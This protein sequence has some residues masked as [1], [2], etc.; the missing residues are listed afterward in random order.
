MTSEDQA[1]QRSIQINEKPPVETKP[2]ES[3]KQF[4]SIRLFLSQYGFCSLDAMYHMFNSKQWNDSKYF[5]RLRPSIKLLDSNT[6]SFVEDL[7]NL[8]RISPMLY[9]TGQIYYLKRHQQNLNESFENL[10]CPEE[11]NPNFLTMVSKLGKVIEVNRHGGWTG[12]LETSWKTINVNASTSNSTTKTL[13][14]IDGLNSIFYW[15]DLTSEMAFYLPHQFS[16]EQQGS[17]MRIV[18][19]WLEEFHNDL[20]SLLPVQD[21]SPKS[22]EI[23]IIGIHPLKNG[24]FR[25]ALNPTAQRMQSTCASIP[26]LDGM[27]VPSY[28]LSFFLRQ[29]V[30]SLNRRK[31]LEDSQSSQTAYSL[32]KSRITKIIEKYQ[33]RSHQLD[34]YFEQI[35]FSTRTASTV[36]QC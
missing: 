10:N 31:R 26:F 1:L 8:D 21:Q 32:R 23:S 3:E 30:H 4:E 19:I 5:D 17:E 22:R 2:P 25:I 7:K 20:D 13:T 9:C 24:L 14:E 12:T 27:V 16:A 33:H 18:I 15:L 36:V 11:L 29:S 28:V 35:F 6:D 34:E